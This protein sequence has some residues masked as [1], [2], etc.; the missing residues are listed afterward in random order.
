MAQDHELGKDTTVYQ[1]NFLLQIEQHI[2]KSILL[3]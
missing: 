1:N 3:Q 2:N